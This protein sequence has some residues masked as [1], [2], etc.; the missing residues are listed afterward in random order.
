MRYVVREKGKVEVGILSCGQCHTRVMPDG[1]IVKGAQGNFPD[2]RTFAYETRLELARATDREAVLREFRGFL[3]RSYAAP[4]L[5]PDPN[6]RPDSMSLAELLPVLEAIP[7]GVCA[8]QGTSIFYPVRIPDLIGIA[9]RRYLDASGHVRHRSIGDVMRYAAINQGADALAQYG[10]FRPAGGELPDPSTLSRYSDEQLY[11]L[12]RYLYSLEP[13]RNPH[14]VDALAVRGRAVFERAG[15]AACH[16]P[17][18]YTNN[19]LTPAEGFT[20]PEAHASDPDVLPV[21]VG[22]DPRLA[23]RSRRGTGF[24]KVPSLL[25][26][27]YRGPFGHDG[28]VPTLEDWL[29]PRRLL[30]EYRSTVVRDGTRRHAVRGHE[31]GLDLSPTDRRALVAFLKT[32]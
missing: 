6:A 21:S 29:D 32:L 13:P 20:V 14:R 30:A 31:F 11:A 23:T 16:T 4:W 1:S 7:A 19:T 5:R 27:W 8:R 17:P 2:D 26:V 28:A 24:Y 12:A 25:G 22:T 15:C 9:G 10:G 18:L 3:R